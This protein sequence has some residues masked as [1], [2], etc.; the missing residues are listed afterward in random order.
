MAEPPENRPTAVGDHHDLDLRG[1]REALRAVDPHDRDAVA[2]LVDPLAVTA[3][4]GSFEAL[5]LLVRAVDEFRLARPA[6]QRLLV[7]DADVDEVAQDVLVAVAETVGSYRGDARF[8]TWLYQVARFKAIA[9]LR[10]T[11][12]TTPLPDD[13]SESAAEGTAGD[14]QRIS[15]IIATRASVAEILESLPALYRGPVTLRDIEELP[16][17]EVAMQLGININTAKTRVAR[18]RALVAARLTS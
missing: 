16:Y 17:D 4:A 13:A 11:R 7:N 3:A 12:P 14:A 8:S 2:A 10:R 1:T 9:H 18:G 5:E 15:S 6:I